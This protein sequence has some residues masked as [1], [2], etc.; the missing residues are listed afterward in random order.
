M[1]PEASVRAAVLAE[2][3]ERV[4]YVRPEWGR[5]LGKLLAQLDGTARGGRCL[6]VLV[7]ARTE[8]TWMHRYCAPWEVR[9]LRGR[10]RLDAHSGSAPFP[11]AVIVMGPVA[12]CRTVGYWGLRTK[13][14]AGSV[15]SK[16]DE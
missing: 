5:G 4:A 13:R 9:F 10:L 15:G 14:V 2:F 8:T 3:G 1:T 11:S 16:G 7:P 6:A 12:R